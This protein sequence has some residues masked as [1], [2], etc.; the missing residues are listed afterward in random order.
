MRRLK[1][2]PARLSFLEQPGLMLRRDRSTRSAA[3]DRIGPAIDPGEINAAHLGNGS[4][5][6]AHFDHDISWGPHPPTF[7]YRKDVVKALVSILEIDPH[8]GFR[9]NGAMN[10]DEMPNE[11][12]ERKLNER[13]HGAKKALADFLHCPPARISKML[14][15]EKG[16]GPTHIPVHD[17]VRMEEFFGELYAPMHQ[18]YPRFARRRR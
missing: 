2:K 1:S 8:C 6:T 17:L 14:N 3:L 11:W 10:G 4:R 13:P 7:D 5:T 12:L 18:N 9:K 15:G 16:S